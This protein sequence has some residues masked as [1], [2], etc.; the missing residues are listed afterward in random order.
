MARKVKVEIIENGKVLESAVAY[1]WM[2]FL[3]GSWTKKRPT[4]P[5]KYIIANRAGRVVG[6][7]FVFFDAETEELAIRIRD[8]ALCK[9][10]EFED[11]N[12]WWWSSPMPLLMPIA[13][14]RS[15]DD[16]PSTDELFGTAQDRKNR[17]RLR[18]LRDEGKITGDPPKA[19]LRSVEDT[20]VN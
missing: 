5:G 4:R 13:V 1:T 19:R 10:K 2:S 20:S 14:P 9:I 6:E 17:A 16:L 12:V 3:N 7:V 18:Q 8:G 11:Q 15:V